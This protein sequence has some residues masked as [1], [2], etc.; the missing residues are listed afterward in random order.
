MEKLTHYREL[1]QK[2]LQD[3]GKLGTNSADAH[4]SIDDRVATQYIFDTQRDHYQLAY[5]GWENNNRRLFGPVIQIDL[6][7]DKIWIQYDGTE[8]GMAN[9]LVA[10][11]V[12]KSD[13]VLAFQAPYKRKWTEFASN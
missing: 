6:K 4:D 1:I 3:Y 7:N 8:I 2:V 9:E 13:I 12:P 11:G 10:L 5:I